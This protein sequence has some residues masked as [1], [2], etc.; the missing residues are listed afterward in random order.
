MF[1]VLQISD[2]F[3]VVLVIDE[4]DGPS[5]HQRDH[6]SQLLPAEVQHRWPVICH[7]A[8][9]IGIHKAQQPRT[10]HVDTTVDEETCQPDDR[11]FF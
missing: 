10:G 9:Q 6:L 7:M 3:D 2:A 8:M 5:V 4:Y 11:C 1:V